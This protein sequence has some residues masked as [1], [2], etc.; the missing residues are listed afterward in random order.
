M[1]GVYQVR[2]LRQKFSDKYILFY[3]IQTSFLLLFRGILCPISFRETFEIVIQCNKNLKIDY[4][5]RKKEETSFDRLNR[6]VAQ[7]YIYI[8]NMDILS[9]VFFYSDGW[10]PR[11]GEKYTLDRCIE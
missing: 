7:I 8:C 10:I 6:Q 9:V 1:K 2:I 3:E 11:S 4:T 5:K